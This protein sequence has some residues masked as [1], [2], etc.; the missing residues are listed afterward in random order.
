MGARISIAII[1]SRGRMG[2]AL[3]HLIEGEFAASCELSGTLHSQSSSEDWSRA[4]TAHVWVDFSLPKSTPQLHQ[5]LA[6]RPSGTQIP[7]LVI[8]TT[9]HAAAEKRLLESIAEKT[10][11]LQSSNFS[12]GVL[13]L[14]KAL[15]FI[16]PVLAASGF[17]PVMMESHHIHKKDAPSGTA[18]TLARATAGLTPEKIHSIRAGEVIGDHRIEFHGHGEVLSLEH[19]AQTREIFARG[20]LETAL[21]LG[22][23][24]RDSPGSTGWLTLDDFFEEKLNV[25]HV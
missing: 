3:A 7:A 9:G 11:V 10:Q 21:W 1:G 23:K 5:A 25:R 20:A 24:H 12:T 14:K 16:S 18:L 2:R 19:H 22:S 15:E 4:M 17:K 6:A 13:A 8:G